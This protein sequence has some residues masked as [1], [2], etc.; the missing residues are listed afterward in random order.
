M[1]LL[2]VELIIFTGGS[3]YYEEKDNVAGISYSAGG[4]L[5]CACGCRD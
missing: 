2:K 3:I 1:K 5:F 4:R